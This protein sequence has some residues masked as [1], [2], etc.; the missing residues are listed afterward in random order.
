MALPS[1]SSRISLF[2]PQQFGKTGG[3]SPKSPPIPTPRL[4]LTVL[5]NT[6][7]SI[8][9][10]VDLSHETEK[11]NHNSDYWCV[12][13]D[14]INSGSLSCIIKLIMLFLNPLHTF[15]VMIHREEEPVRYANLMYEKRVVRGNTYALHV[16]PWV[17]SSPIISSYS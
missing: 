1:S 11:L 13:G 16:L 15:N 6:I 7:C 14:F 5:L 8:L 3:A 17:S 4:P 12:W 9:T 10:T 2:W